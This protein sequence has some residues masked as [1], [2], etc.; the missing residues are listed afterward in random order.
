MIRKRGDK[1]VV[2]DAE[3]E[4]VLGEHDTKE[5]AEKQLR[6]IEAR[7][8]MKK[9]RVNILTAVNAA[10]VKIARK[11]ID[12]DKFAVIQNVK[13][14]HDDIVLNSGL[15]PAAENAKGYASMDGRLMPFGHPEVNGQYVA[16]SNLDNPASTR[17]LARHYGGVHAENVRNERGEYFADVMVNE[18]AAS[19]HPDGEMLL[20]WIGQAE[21][22]QSPKPIHMST[23]VMLQRVQANGESKGVKYDWIAVNQQ[24]DHLAILFHERGAGGDAVSIAV[25]CDEVLHA[26]LPAVNEEA[27]DDSY[28][29][30]MALIDA[31]VKERYATTDGYAF[32]M[33]FDDEAVIVKTNDR[34]F[35]VRYRMEDGNPI[36]GDEVGDVVSKTVYEMKRNSLVE[37]MLNYLRKPK[38]TIEEEPDM[39]PEEVQAI[40][41]KAVGVVNAKLESSDATIKELEGKL[42]DA[43][44]ANQKAQD[45]E[46]RALVKEH[47]GEVVANSLQGEALAA[48]AAKFQKAAPLLGGLAGNSQEDEFK[49]YSL[50]EFAK[51]AK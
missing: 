14:M 41:D 25:N 44:A 38:P 45:E 33:D 46:L 2:L 51:E 3:G 37:R 49:D 28:G 8:H 36:L 35:K 15:Y 43:I 48:A 24:Y 11:E 27:L 31:A 40:V 17:A 9:T 30:Q 18:R 34:E 7:K 50:N 47:L 23:G 12:G 13:W 10:S 21:S 32:A 29:E 26:E 19:S 42:A 1:W 20:N 5:E 16:I 22:G 6:A 4:K 39:T